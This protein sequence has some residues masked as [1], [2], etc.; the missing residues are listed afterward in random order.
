MNSNPIKS[1]TLHLHGVGVSPGIAVA[2]VVLY[3]SRIIKPPMYRLEADALDAEWE[4][5]LKAKDVTRMQLG[6][7]R[8]R[9]DACSSAGEAGIIDGHLMVLDDELLVADVRKAIFE[10]H[11]NAEWAVRDV[12]NYY[13]LKFSSS[14]DA[15]FRE[16]ADDIADVSRRLIRNLMGV[17]EE[18]PGQWDH[19]CVVVAENLTPSETLALP[20]DV[21]KAV[22]LDRGSLTSHAALVIRAIGIPAVFG[23][24]T[25]S[26]SAVSGQ[27]IGV[28]G[29][30]G[31]VLLNPD[32]IDLTHLFG[33]AERRKQIL[34]SLK[35]L[36]D[37]PA[38]TP[39][40]FRV[41]LL[42]N[43]EN[44]DDLG[45]LDE[46]GAEGVGLF[47]TEY[48]WLATGKPV[49]EVEQTK[50]YQAVADAMDGRPVV[51][52]AFDLGGDKF[53]GGIG[54]SNNE[55]NPFLGLRSLRY[56]LRNE[57]VFKAQIRAILRACREADVR[58][59]LPMVTE[60]YE[61]TRA[62]E[63]INE[64]LDRMSMEGIAC[65]P[66]KL[67][68]MIE[69]P[70]AALMAQLMVKQVDFVS[71]GSND[72]TQYTMAADRTNELVAHLYQPAH[73]AVLQL[74]KMSA[75]AAHN[76]SVP[77]CLCG[78]MAADP[79]LAVLLLGMRFDS[80]SMAASSIPIIK[81][82][83]RNVP[84]AEAEKLVQMALAAG[85]PETVLEMSRSFLAKYVPDL[86]LV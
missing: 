51:I 23:L 45:P 46:N 42:A 74:L 60:I 32:K 16:R 39:D 71:V 47:R 17:K 34:D 21:V 63:L 11:H 68:L 65:P 36:R 20:R 29:N 24:G 37:E 10:K 6:E 81:S 77:L 31:L 53:M 48:L 7:L 84:V 44:A 85:I 28:D 73:P 55:K 4:R 69:V 57:D 5:H 50:A 75:D 8:A 9:L 15:Y 14:E 56:L 59:L 41:K 26:N 19:P 58:I 13:I 33:L 83:I 62:R 67:G 27:Q 35:P 30:K 72:L 43:I 49:D 79:A 61:L 76:A 1:P 12:A 18:L 78:E 2:P 86:L 25:I 54:L 66:P 22:V 40:G 82:L 80:L 38:I 64:C 3:R 52:R 70:S